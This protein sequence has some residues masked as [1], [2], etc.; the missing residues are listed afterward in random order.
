MARKPE[1]DEAEA[2]GFIVNPVT[3]RAVLDEQSTFRVLAP[4]GVITAL[5][6]YAPKVL[7]G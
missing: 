2:N 7:D 3:T 6:S 4:A 5:P 1:L